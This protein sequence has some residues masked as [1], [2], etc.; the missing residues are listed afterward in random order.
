MCIYIYAY[1][2]VSVFVHIFV[3]EV[4]FPVRIGFR[5][6]LF[7]AAGFALQRSRLPS[8]PERGEKLQGPEDYM[9]P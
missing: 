7:V 4:E 6:R 8:G 3:Y 9:R 5:P 2:H 1:V